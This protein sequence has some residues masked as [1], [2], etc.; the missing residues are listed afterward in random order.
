MPKIYATVSEKTVAN[1]KNISEK[2]RKSFSRIV[3]EIIELGLLSYKN[4][5]TATPSKPIQKMT[6]L[7]SKHTEYLLR[8]LNI[9]SEI[10]RKLYN[11]PSKCTKKTVDSMLT[12][13]KTHVKNRIENKPNKNQ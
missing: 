6:E 5:L 13:I 1:L 7:D 3:H 2:N 12:E 4:Q 9:D 8:I 10:L 11:E